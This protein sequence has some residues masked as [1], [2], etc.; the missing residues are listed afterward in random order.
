MQVDKANDIWFKQVLGAES[1]GLLQDF[2]L[3]VMPL[4]YY[5]THAKHES[6]ARAAR[7]PSRHTSSSDIASNRLSTHL[8]FLS[9]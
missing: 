7:A 4:G 5:C 3:R 8:H 2:T 6:C 1:E 9:A